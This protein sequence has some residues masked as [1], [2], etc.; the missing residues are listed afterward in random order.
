MSSKLGDVGRGVVRGQDTRSV[1]LLTLRRSLL[2]SLRAP[3]G[4]VGHPSSRS[5]EV[6]DH[7]TLKREVESLE[8]SLDRLRRL[9]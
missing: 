1:K 5:E 9:S 4:D 2:S 3:N 8:S 6:G 7:E